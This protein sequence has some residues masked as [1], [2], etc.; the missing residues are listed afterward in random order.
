MSLS[1]ATPTS[2]IRSGF[3][4]AYSRYL[5]VRL[6]APMATIVT[7]FVSLVRSICLLLF[8]RFRHFRRLFLFGGVLALGPLREFD[9]QFIQPV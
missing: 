3:R 2:F 5:L 4:I 9:A 1:S 8:R 7:G 6:P